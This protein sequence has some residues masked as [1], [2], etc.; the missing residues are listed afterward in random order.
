[1]WKYT[2]RVRPDFADIPGPGQE[3]VW[4]Y[5]RPPR[6]ESAGKFVEVKYE[7]MVLAASRDCLRL[8]E[9]ASPP[10][11]YLPPNDVNGALL[12]PAPGQSFCEWKGIASYW[13]MLGRSDPVSWSYPDP[14]GK[15]AGLAGYFSF[16]PAKVECYVNGERV[17][18]QPGSFYGGWV[19]GDLTGPFK[20]DPGT[21][22][23]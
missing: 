3:S 17:R 12:E 2:G 14:T 5:P 8:V 20:G 1:M 7:D 11:Y 4:D 22:G 19:T 16:Y 10:T 15:Y 18:P 21:E 6:L 23:W 13:S 9:T